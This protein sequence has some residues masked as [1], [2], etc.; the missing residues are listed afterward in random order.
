M[1]SIY[2]NASC[3]IK[4]SI[5]LLMTRTVVIMF[6]EER[7]YVYELMDHG[8]NKLRTSGDQSFP[9]RMVVRSRNYSYTCDGHFGR[10]RKPEAMF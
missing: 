6:F 7:G 4:V 3:S 9:E 2:K 10:L 8:I 5:T 1:D